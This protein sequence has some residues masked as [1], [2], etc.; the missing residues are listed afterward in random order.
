MSASD[1]L[2][3]SIKLHDNK[4]DGV[5]STINPTGSKVGT[6]PGTERGIRFLIG[7]SPQEKRL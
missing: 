5:V 2:P 6:D 1:S 7:Y 3:M 4:N